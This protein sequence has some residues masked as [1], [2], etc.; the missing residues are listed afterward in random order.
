MSL[1][2]DF[3]SMLYDEFKK[4][5]HEPLEVLEAAR[6]V[7]LGTFKIFMLRR[8]DAVVGSVDEIIYGPRSPGLFSSE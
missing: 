3:G 4:V 2:L 8:F 7:D 5:R 1:S 6:L